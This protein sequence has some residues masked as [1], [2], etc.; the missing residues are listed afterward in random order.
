MADVSSLSAKKDRIIASVKLGMSFD[1]AAILAETTESDRETLK[2][3]KVFQ[4]RMLYT[5]RQREQELL[6][7]INERLDVCLEKGKL[8]EVLRMLE[9]LNPERYAKKATISSEDDD[10]MP[11][12][13]VSFK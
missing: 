8:N 6:T 3:D 10:E 4:E 11:N 5:K 13:T 7:M 9:V 12:I 2:E 1:D